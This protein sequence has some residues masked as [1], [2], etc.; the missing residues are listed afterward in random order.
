M[1]S[2]RFLSTLAVGS[3][4]LWLSA[5]A[6]A[7]MAGGAGFGGMQGANNFSPATGAAPMAG[8]MSSQQQ[9]AQIYM[10]YGMLGGGG[11]SNVTSGVAN[12]FANGGFGM[13]SL[14]YLDSSSPGGNAPTAKSGSAARK[15][16]L[17]AQRAEQKS[18]AKSAKVKAPKVKPASKTSRLK[19]APAQ[20]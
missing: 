15:A 18:Q 4:L 3:I 11:R 8:G 7:Q 16:A 12:P 20:Q 17:R 9:M 5:I 2:S 10:L 14:P 13:G 19:N 1:R 6:S